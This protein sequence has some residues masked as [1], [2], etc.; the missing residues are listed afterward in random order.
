[1]QNLTL[2]PIENLKLAK[3]AYVRGEKKNAR[4]WASLAVSQD[5]NLEE[6]WLILAAVANPKASVGILNHYLKINPNSQRAQRGLT[7]AIKRLES[8]PPVGTSSTN[9]AANHLTIRSSLRPQDASR[10]NNFRIPKQVFSYLLIIIFSFIIIPFLT[11][12]II[13]FQIPPTLIQ[14]TK[15]TQQEIPQTLVKTIQSGQKTLLKSS[16]PTINM[17]VTATIMP[18]TATIVP[19]TETQISTPITSPTILPSDTPVNGQ[20]GPQTFPASPDQ[21][22]PSTGKWILVDISEQHMYVYEKNQ[23]A[24]SFIASTGMNRSTRV[25]TFAI[26]SKIPNAYGATWDIWMPDWLGIYYSGSLENGIHALPILQNGATLWDG[27]LGTPISYGCVV[28]GSYDA[29]TLYNW[30]EIGIPVI[31]QP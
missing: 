3:D 14:N 8:Y 6:A 15:S 4:Y 18:S 30:A 9:Y 12:I 27:F 7:W 21:T 31:I 11:G 2:A 16:T 26:Q 20:T 5:P 10:E 28:L 23:I 25:G 29:E 22:F 1:M 19:S 24:F 13:N 17:I